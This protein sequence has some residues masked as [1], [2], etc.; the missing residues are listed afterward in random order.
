MGSEEVVE[1]ILAQ[2]PG[3]TRSEIQTMIREKKRAS[4]DLLSNE[5][6][7]RL[8]AQDLLVESSPTRLESLQISDIIPRLSD[9]TL[10]GR[11]LAAWPKQTFKRKDGTQGTFFRLLLADK[12]GT[13]PCL[14]W[15]PSVIGALEPTEI[16]GRIVRVTHSYT[17]PGMTERVE[18]HVGD[19]GDINLLPES[20]K[21]ET[22]PP[23]QAFIKRVD[24]ISDETQPTNI[25]GVV[26]TAPT[27]STFQKQ[28]TTGMVLRMLIKDDTGIVNVVAWNEKADELKTIKA[29]DVIRIINGR[30]KRGVNGHPEI[31]LNKWSLVRLL[32]PSKR[33]PKLQTL[34]SIADLKPTSG[35][36]NVLGRVV[37]IEPLLEIQT[38][39]GEKVPISRI[40]I[41]DKTG[42]II[43]TLWRDNS[44]LTEGLE[45]GSLVLV[46]NAQTQERNEELRLNLSKTG[47]LISDLGLLGGTDPGDPPV[48]EIVKLKKSHQPIIVEGVVVEDASPREVE[49]KNGSKVEVASF[50]IRESGETARVSFWRDLAHGA[51]ALRI[52]DRIRIIGVRVKE[53]FTDKWELHSSSLTRLEKLGRETSKVQNT[54]AS[55]P[56]S[57]QQKSEV[58]RLT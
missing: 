47:N 22:Y 31:H 21:A 50:R 38:R 7:A 57:N 42:L 6:A 51:T 30:A 33:P 41:G 58:V 48:T 4:G 24:E 55:P 17:R 25:E 1:R 29:N 23:L 37:S 56:L 28:E 49:L 26:I 11:I 8:V 35:R 20:F 27:I 43:V 39:S 34:S 10:T 46:E 9:A 13:V 15:N 5:G 53:G 14:V 12:T 52:G 19:R 18:L 2:R 32:G 54:N 16:E 44:R 3:I 45:E 40:L 36:V